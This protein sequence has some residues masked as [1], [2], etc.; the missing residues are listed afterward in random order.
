MFTFLRSFARLILTC[1][2]LHHNDKVL[3]VNNV[4]GLMNDW[5]KDAKMHPHPLAKLLR[6]C[7][8]VLSYFKRTSKKVIAPMY[9]W[10]KQHVLHSLSKFARGVFKL[11]LSALRGA[12]HAFCTL[13]RHFKHLH[14]K[15]SNTILRDP[16]IGENHTS[17]GSDN[18]VRSEGMS[19]VDRTADKF[20]SSLDKTFSEQFLQP[21]VRTETSQWRNGLYAC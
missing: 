8:S 13:L 17:E 11:T 10:V 21:W 6:H 12:K 19:E 16:E 20:I 15:N 4:I 7:V 2:V 1:R 5:P 14:F 9:F 3:V 18:V